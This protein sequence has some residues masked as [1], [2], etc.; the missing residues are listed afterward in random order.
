[1]EPVKTQEAVASQSTTQNTQDTPITLQTDP[2]KRM[3]QINWNMNLRRSSSGVPYLTADFVAEQG[4]EVRLFDLRGDEELQGFLGHIPGVVR[5]SP[6]DISVLA[7]AFSPDTPI[8]LISNN[9]ERAGKAAI[10]LELLGMKAVA[11][12]GGGM[13][14]WKK[15]GYTVSRHQRV[16]KRVFSLE[17]PD[18][19]RE[20]LMALRASL[21]EGQKLEGIHVDRHLGDPANVRWIRMAALLMHG[22]RS[23]VDGR[24][25][26]GVIGTPGGDAGE[27]LLALA[28]AEKVT[29]QRIEE[30]VLPDLLMAYMDAFGRFYMHTDTHAANE[31]IRSIRQDPRLA[32]QV[33]FMERAEEWRAFFDSPPQELREPLLEH[34]SKPEHIGCG[35]LRLMMLHEEDYGIRRELIEAFLRTY[36]TSRWNWASDLEFVVLGGAHNEGA[37]INVQINEDL[38]TFTKLPLVSPSCGGLSQFFVNHPQV[39]DYM[40]HQT[41]LFMLAQE[42]LLPLRSDHRDAFLEEIRRLSQVQMMNT[43]GYLAK[44]LPVYEVC[45]HAER[46]FT[47]EEK[48]YIP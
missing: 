37:V 1:M 39:S 35:H 40:R 31:M 8:V 36:H 30:T 25:E 9:G 15:L 27:F 26:K 47:L 14:A 5:I 32:T 20:D 44:G 48:G 2:A 12:L 11:S 7:K 18:V 45:F 43:L 3:L 46:T 23:C 28:A 13:E 10:Y 4:R 38:Q 6:A 34:L 19:G 41:A 16:L 42:K 17:N 33:P 29:G 24:D 21:K 22:K